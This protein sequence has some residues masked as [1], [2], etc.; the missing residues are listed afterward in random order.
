MTLGL[1][2]HFTFGVTRETYLGQLLHIHVHAKPRPPL[3]RTPRAVV[4]LVNCVHLS[5][6]SSTCALGLAAARL[7]R[8]YSETSMAAAELRRRRG[9]LEP[10]RASVQARHALRRAHI[11]AAAGDANATTYAR[12][13]RRQ[14]SRL[15]GAILPR[16]ACEAKRA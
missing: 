12:W 1:L 7:A 8:V 3:V 5:T 9:S 15:G 16:M 6:S 10:N 11:K 14:S 13:H 4:F 2:Y